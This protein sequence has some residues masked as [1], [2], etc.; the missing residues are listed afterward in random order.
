MKKA[1]LWIVAAVMVLALGA[2]WYFS[3]GSGK[4]TVALPVLTQTTTAASPVEAWREKRTAQRKEDIAT[5]Q[6][7]LDRTGLDEDAREDAVALLTRLV[8]WSEEETALEGALA[9]SG[10]S[11]CA[12]MR[13]EGMV[14]LVTEKATLSDGERALLLTM[15]QTHAGVPPEGVQVVTAE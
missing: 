4:N 12:A 2:A 10:I 1:R 11:P 13:S 15:A 9:S 6:A 5:L 14:T 8:Q 7:L 3:R